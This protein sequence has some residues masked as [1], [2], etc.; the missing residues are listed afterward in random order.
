MDDNY[1]V[2]NLLAQGWT[3]F[4]AIQKHL[5]IS[6]ED[7]DKIMEWLLEEDYIRAYTI[8]QENHGN[9]LYKMRIL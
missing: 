2:V 3:D 6:D 4:D 8:H 5:E 9:Q 1:K 7:M